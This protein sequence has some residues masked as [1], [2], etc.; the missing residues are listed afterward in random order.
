MKHVIKWSTVACLAA[1]LLTISCSH[2]PSQE[3]SEATSTAIVS[4][5]EPV[6]EV[7]DAEREVGSNNSAGA[8]TVKTAIRFDTASDTGLEFTHMAGRSAEKYMPETM[9]GGVILAD[10]NRDAAPDVLF[11]NSGHFLESKQI[12]PAPHRL[13]IN[14]G[15]GNF[16][17]QTE[18]WQV[19]N[20]GYGMGAA[21]ADFDNDGWTDLYLTTF[22]GN[23]R[24]LHNT[25]HAFEDVTER[26]GLAGQSGWS[27]SAGFFDMDQ[28]GD[29]DL[30]VVKYVHY[31]PE[32]AIPCF[33]QG[34]QVYCTPVMFEA[35]G[36]RLFRNNGDGTF[37]D[38][39]QVA[40]IPT[41]GKGLALAIGDI[42]RDCDA[43][44]YVAND[45]TANY[46]LI[47]DGHGK[48][49]EKAALLGVGYSNFGKEEAGMGVDFADVN[50]DGLPDIACT[51]FQG[52]TT[53]IYVQQAK[54]YFIEQSDEVGVGETARQRLKFGLDFFDA[55]NDGD[56]DLIVANGHIYAEVE[57]FNKGIG[58]GQLNTLYEQQD[59][60]L[61]D[62]TLAAG[63]ALQTRL[64]S[65][66]LATGDL[67]ND[68]D[69]D[70]VVVNTNT[71]AEIA[72]NA[73]PQ[74]GN[75]VSLWLEGVTCNRS[76][77]G[78]L[79]TAIVGDRHTT[80]EVLGASSYLSASDPRVHLG[81]GGASQV[82]EVRIRW[83]DGNQQTVSGLKAGAY[84]HWVEGHDPVPIEPGEQVFQPE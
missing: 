82:D 31:S 75:F 34:Y 16:V 20:H 76:A 67:D 26:A 77:I 37:T 63:P 1:I 11:I 28:D 59:G 65:R 3:S 13:F 42:D 40:A 41:E 68:G 46:L 10:F 39:S 69:L 64:P 6:A 73:T 22:D 57:A 58:Y 79:V 61:V 74:A 72:L 29:L 45:T 84:Y 8:V 27:T 55:D 25:G 19:T 44:I 56:E 4:P 18:T 80:R 49:E 24:L 32:T 51:N 12:E 70:F 5:L 33:F 30:Y 54:G 36:D 17:D 23:D 15:Q 38:V 62:V 14:Q 71:H 60:R 81:L 83:P 50:D 53:S 43:D 48:F 66:G 21:A 7:T 35:Q 78:A 9:G 47:N 52:E 2:Q